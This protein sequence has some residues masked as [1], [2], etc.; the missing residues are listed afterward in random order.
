M[1]AFRYRV[2][3]PSGLVA[4]FRDL[5]D[6][7]RFAEIKCRSS[8]GAATYVYDKQ[9]NQSQTLIAAYLHGKRQG[10]VTA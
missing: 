3:T 7:E 8:K 10:L 4:G 9:H 5:E 1:A 2:V 6:A